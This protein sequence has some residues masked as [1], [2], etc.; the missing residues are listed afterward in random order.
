MSLHASRRGKKNT[1]EEAN[2]YIVQ[3]EKYMPE[4]FQENENTLHYCPNAY[5]KW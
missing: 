5:D 4:V 2:M 1:Q 3:R